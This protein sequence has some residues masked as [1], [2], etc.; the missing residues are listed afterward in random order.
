VLDPSLHVRDR[1]PGIGFKPLAIEV[2]GSQAQLDNEVAREI[3]W[4]NLAALLL[5]Q[6]EQGLFILAHDDAGVGTADEVTASGVVQSL[7]L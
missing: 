2:L 1:V 5:P 4:P 7:H 3:L 6:P